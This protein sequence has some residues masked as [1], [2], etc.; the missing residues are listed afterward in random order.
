MA[1]E[2][3]TAGAGSARRT[4]AGD[5]SRDV[6]SQGTPD[7]WRT[8]PGTATT[9]SAFPQTQTTT[10]QPGQRMADAQG[11]RGQAR[12]G[13][14]AASGRNLMDRAREGALNRLDSQRERAASGLTSMVDALRQGGQYIEQQNPTIASY[15]DTAASQLERFTGG[16]RDRNLTQIV[17]DVERFARRRPAVFLGSAFVLGVV[18]ARFLKSSAPENESWRV[19]SSWPASGAE[20]TGSRESDDVRRQY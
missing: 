18:A 8:I 6:S 14:L 4:E 3:P 17:T 16:I 7:T 12:T 13:D 20:W 11:T 2:R 10:G 9:T 5:E 19:S 1:T 15:V